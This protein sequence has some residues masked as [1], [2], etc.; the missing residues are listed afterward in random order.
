MSLRIQHFF[1]KKKKT[2][3]RGQQA[4]NLDPRKQNLSR[5]NLNHGQS[6]YNQIIFYLGDRIVAQTSIDEVVHSLLKN[7]IKLGPSK[8]REGIE[9]SFG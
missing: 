5:L 2:V 4:L 7:F 8:G 1:F 3:K 9:D 6:G